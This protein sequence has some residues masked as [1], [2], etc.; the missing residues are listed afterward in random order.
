MDFFPEQDDECSHPH[1]FEKFLELK[2]TKKALNILRAY[3][4]IDI[5]FIIYDYTESPCASTH[6]LVYDSLSYRLSIP[7]FLIKESWRRIGKIEE[8]NDMI[9]R[10]ARRK[11]NRRKEYRSVDGPPSNPCF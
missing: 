7:P 1:S 4:L 9:K 11:K 8:Y 5:V 2:S 6:D 3:L 10:K